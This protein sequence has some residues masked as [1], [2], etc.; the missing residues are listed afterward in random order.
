MKQISLSRGL[1]A[2]VDDDDFESLSRHKW[3]AKPD[4]S[5]NC[6]AMRVGATPTSKRS[7]ITMHREIMR[8]G[9]GEHIDH[10]NRNG[11]D[12]RRSNLRICTGQEN[13]FNTGPKSTESGYKGVNWHTRFRKWQAR[14]RKDG[15]LYHLGYFS[16]KHAAA[17]VYNFAANHLFGEFAF[18]NQIDPGSVIRK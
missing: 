14:I 1:T 10:I 15:E 18:L 8:A 5:G 9:S 16:N 6:Y 7:T 11:L 12:N 3:Q 2:T 4:A 13:Q 17:V